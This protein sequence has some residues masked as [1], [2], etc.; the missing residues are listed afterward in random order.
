MAEDIEDI[1]QQVFLKLF[2]DNFRRLRE[3]K[4]NDENS[5]RF[6]L[7]DV[8]NNMAIDSLK[9]H[10]AARRPLVTYSLN[11]AISK[12]DQQ[13]SIVDTL[14]AVDGNPEELYL[15]DELN[16]QISA[17]IKEEP[18]PLKRVRDEKIFEAYCDGESLNEIAAQPDIGLKRTAIN[19]RINWLKE[20]VKKVLTNRPA[21]FTKN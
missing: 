3:F 4:S 21:T 13:I 16:Q 2:K 8:A 17:I 7:F 1:L 20:K 5:L 18:D 12:N 19:S 6:F 9:Y 14:A 10:R 11:E 15:I